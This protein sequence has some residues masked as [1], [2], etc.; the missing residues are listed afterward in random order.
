MVACGNLFNESS[1]SDMLSKSSDGDDAERWS[2]VPS[3]G[4]QFSKMGD[5]D[6]GEILPHGDDTFSDISA[7]LS[8]DLMNLV[9]DGQISAPIVELYD[10]GSTWHISPYKDKFVS[11]TAILLKTFTAAN[12]Q[13]FN[14][15]VIGDLV[16]N[17][18]NGC[19]VTKLRLTEVLYLPVVGYALVSIG[20]LDQ[21]GYSVTF[22]DGTCTI[23]SPDD[24]VIRCVPKSHTGLYHVIH[25]GA[26]NGV[27]AAV[28]TVTVMELHCRMGHISP[29]VARHLAEN[30]LVSGLKFDLL[31][32]KPTFC[33]A[34]VYVKATRK[35]V[36]KKHVGEH[37]MEF[38]AEVHTDV[39]GPAP[40]KMIGE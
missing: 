5:T 36:A 17:M 38:S 22:A 29:T 15:T 33:E 12:K 31:K 11:L 21:L 1:T 18:P 23:R 2:Y 8:P 19:D 30:G 3:E 24:N 35:P 26:H 37:A 27:N 39:W 32:D 20:C 25:T 28:E 34:C 10:S 13:S 14:A 4:D 6:D 16:I 40:I 9:H 7:E